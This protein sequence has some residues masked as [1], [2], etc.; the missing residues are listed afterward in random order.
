MVAATGVGLVTGN[1]PRPGFL[2]S[3]AFEGLVIE[4]GTVTLPSDWF[5][6]ANGSPVEISITDAAIGT[7][8]ASNGRCR[9][10][11]R[12]RHRRVAGS[13]HH[14]HRA[15]ERRGQRARRRCGRAR[16]RLG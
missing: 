13:P 3:D 12:S 9:T 16:R 7:S 2:D 15:S 14:V 5:E 11:R 8:S 4:Q 6:D 1:M 10:G